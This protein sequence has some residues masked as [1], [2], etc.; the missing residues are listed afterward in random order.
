[1]GS[2]PHGGSPGC[3]YSNFRAREAPWQ[4][5]VRASRGAVTRD[6]SGPRPAGCA[7]VALAGARKG[8]R[9][10]DGHCPSA[11]GE[12][13]QNLRSPGSRLKIACAAWCDRRELLIARGLTGRAAIADS[14]TP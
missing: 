1:M 6:R 10:A 9:L 4:R 3:R 7:E 13:A 8:P 2:F 5:L 11:H 14:L 12:I